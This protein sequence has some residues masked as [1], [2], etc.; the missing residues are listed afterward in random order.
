MH[1]AY[2]IKNDHQRQFLGLTEL[3]NRK[4]LHLYRAKLL[5]NYKIKRL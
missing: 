1:G 2:I 3:L 4:T 5:Q